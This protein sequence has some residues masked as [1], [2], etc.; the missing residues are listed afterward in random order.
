MSEIGTKRYLTVE[1]GGVANGV[2]VRLHNEVYVVSGGQLSGGAVLNGG[3]VSGFATI[4]GTVTVYGGGDV[5]GATV[6]SGGVDVFLP[7]ALE[8]V[9]VASGGLLELAALAVKSGVTSVASVET[10]TTFVSG[11]SLSSGAALDFLRLTVSSGGAL[12]VSSGGLAQ[13]VALAPG[14][15]A[16]VFAGGTIAAVTVSHG[17]T[18]SGPGVVGGAS[19]NR[20]AVYGAD[21]AGALA[22]SSGAVEQAGTILSGGVETVSSGGVAS[23]TT[24]LS[25]G[26]LTLTTGA[27][28]YATVVTGGGTAAIAKGGVANGAT[29]LT[30]GTLSGPGALAGASTDAGKIVSAVVSGTVA[31]SSG[32]VITG[33]SIANGA[34]ITVLSGGT[35]T[36]VTASNGGTLIDD[37]MAV[38]SGATTNALSAS[39]SGSGTVVENG[40]GVLVFAGGTSAFSGNLVISGGTAELA[41]AQGIGAGLVG[42]AS[43]KA[44][45][46]L[47]VDAVDTP[48]A[49][50]IF[51]STLSNFDQTYDALD[52]RGL[53]F[54]AGAKAVLSGSTLVVTDGG[55]VIRFQLAGVAAT[56]Y[57]AT[58]DGA[59]GTLIKPTTSNHVVLS[60]PGFVQAMAAFGAS[61]ATPQGGYVTSVTNASAHLVANVGSA[62]L[63]WLARA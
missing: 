55:A 58:S 60:Q 21:L 41:T 28:S 5:V 57:G 43:T 3:F 9:A 61:A 34:Q 35:M 32:G 45:A 12:Q 4:T 8:S 44:T 40:T 50:S 39:L 48:T 31:V 19:I 16:I 47:R 42:W 30:G 7:G 54:V 38:F 36:G 24:I 15:S 33:G 25:G 23:A 62:F 37:G 17:A 29:V 51:A 22:V 6:A 53:A 27:T 18:L 1:S 63:G 13:I 59:G 14:A 10:T 52:I 20:G 26:K 49:G 46:T 2:T 11:V 56:T